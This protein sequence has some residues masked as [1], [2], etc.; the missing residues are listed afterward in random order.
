[1]KVLGVIGGLGPMA[2]AYFLELMTGMTNVA[3]DQEHIPVIVNSIPQTPDRTAFILDHKEKSPLKNM[4]EAGTKLKQVGAEYIAIPC[5][6]A[7]YFYHEL[8]E[9][10]GLPIISLLEK[11]REQFENNG[12]KKVGLLATTGTI[13]SR[14]VQNALQNK[15]IQTVLPDSG[16]QAIVMKIIYEQI[17]AGKPVEIEKFMEVEDKLKEK[18]AQKL[19]LGCTELSLLKRDFQLRDENVDVLEI[20]AA[21]AIEYSGLQVKQYHRLT[22]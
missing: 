9:Q 2:T 7:H 3:S 19:L 21:A 16:Q 4:V 10:I 6:T 14:I 17:K 1:M 11:V 22:I 8:E 5:V 18:G 20:L 13:E 15:G 12:I